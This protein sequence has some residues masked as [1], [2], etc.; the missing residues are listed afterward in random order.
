MRVGNMPCGGCEGPLLRISCEFARLPCAGAPAS[1][2]AHQPTGPICRL[3][4]SVRSLAF[5]RAVEI[6]PRNSPPRNPAR[7]LQTGI[8]SSARQIGRVLF[9]HRVRAPMYM[10]LL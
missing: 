3:P 5:A 2:G 9:A 8:P 4:S 7:F 10:T 6:D 1:V